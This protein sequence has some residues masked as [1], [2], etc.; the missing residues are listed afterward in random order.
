MAPLKRMAPVALKE[1]VGTAP[2]GIAGASDPA[3][4]SMLGIIIGIAVVVSA[5]AIGE[6]TRA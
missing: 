5:I 4:L 3:V 1:A 6:G 2:A